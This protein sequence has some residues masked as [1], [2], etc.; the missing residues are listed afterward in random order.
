MKRFLLMALCVLVIHPAIAQLRYGN[1]VT[2]DTPV[3]ED[4]YITGGN[5]T[6]NAPVHGDLIIAG[7]RIHINDTVTNDILVAG[8][9]VTLNGYAGDDVRCAGGN[10]LILKNVVGDVVGTGGTITIAKNVM[11]GSLLS[12]SGEITIDGKV[13]GNVKC[14]AGNLVIN[15]QVMKTLDARAD[16]IVINGAVQGQSLLSATDHILIGNQAQLGGPVRYWVPGGKANFGQSLQNGQAV[17]DPSLRIGD[18]HWYFMGFANAAGL[19]WYICTVLLMITLIQ[20]LF[21]AT[22]QK[23]GN[24]ASAS[25]LKS[26]GYGLLFWVGVPIAVVVAL[27]T[28]IGVPVALIL[29]VIYITVALLATTMVAVVVANWLN[30]RSGTKWSFWRLV[31]AALA[32]FVVLKII[33][34]TPFFGWLLILIMVCMATGAI[35]LNINWRKKQAPVNNTAA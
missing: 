4:L 14:V 31:F 23:A 24:T 29:L 30:N 11:V 7:G 6:I 2:I 33:T 12:G 26:L 15:G 13:A 21:G 25:I 18:G 27:I 22:M 3:W 16:K 20:Y 32:I 9:E 8:G 19:L 1:T 28:V 5:I 17:Y 35:L 10:L 34:F